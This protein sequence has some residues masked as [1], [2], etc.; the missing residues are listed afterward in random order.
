MNYPIYHNKALVWSDEFEGNNL[1]YSK[2]ECAVDA[3][4]G[5]NN[6]LQIYTDDPRN[7][8]VE[9]SMLILEAH[10]GGAVAGTTRPFSSGKVRSKHR[11]DWTHG[12]FEVRA[13]LPIGR[14]L[15]SAI[16]MLPTD[17][18][19]GGWAASGEIDIMEARGHLPREICAAIHYG[20]AWPHNKIYPSDELG[21]G[22]FYCDYFH[23]FALDWTKD[24]MVWLIDGIPC[25]SASRDTS[26]GR[27][28]TDENIT[29]PF[30]QRFHLLL[31][32]AVGGRFPGP[33]DMH[34]RFPARMEID[35]V[36]VWQ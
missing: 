22:K 12:L 19:Y 9:N 28:D 26:W 36:R 14:G 21:A 20:G 16:W 24:L 33:P 8:R 3:F 11:G 17:E 32:L 34:T 30:D 25:W 5:G 35:W 10:Q 29:A 23:T 27:H 4:G 2:W 13:K 31:N 15:W 18:I 1:D 7:V 6:E